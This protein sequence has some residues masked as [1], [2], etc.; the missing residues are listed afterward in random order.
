MERFIAKRLRSLPKSILLL[1]PRQVG[2]STLLRSLKPDLVINLADET[3]Y[4]NFLSSP[5]RLNE[6]IEASEPKVVFI[7]EIQRIP[8][9]LNSVQAI[10]DAAVKGSIK[11]LLSGSS[12]RKLKKGNANLLPG[13]IIQYSMGGL[14]VLELKDNFDIKLAMTIGF[15]PEPYLSKDRGLS[16]RLLETYSGT[17]L[18][19]EIQMEAERLDLQGFARFMNEA[20]TNSGQILDFTKLAKVSKISRNSARRYYEMLEDS[21]IMYRVSAF[22]GLSSTVNLV[23][24]PKYYLFDPGVWNGFLQNFKA[25]QD[26]KGVIFEHVVIAQ[27]YNC[28]YAADEPVSVTWVRTHSGV[29]VDFVLTFPRTGR[30]VPI[31]VKAGSEAALNLKGLEWFYKEYPAAK[32]GLCVF[33]QVEAERK[34]GQTRITSLARMCDR[35]FG[36]SK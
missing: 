27:I 16:E 5:S 26:R 20:A 14:S 7:D 8:A 17:Y 25:S 29:E 11:F 33:P 30:V 24:H 4:L 3:T 21:L 34:I 10:L 31:E 18:K 15:L 32:E 23:K 35:L 2:K 28:A 36:S 1:G 22:Q 12:A 9:L 6:I 13:R 19:E